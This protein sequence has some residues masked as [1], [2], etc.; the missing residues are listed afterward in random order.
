MKKTPRDYQLKCINESI[1]TLKASHEPSLL[2]ACV[3]SGKSLMLAEIMRHFVGYGMNVLCVVANSELVRSNAETYIEQGGAASIFCASLGSRCSKNNAVFASP[4]TLMSAIKKEEEISNKRFNL[5]VVDEAHNINV[6]SPNSALIKIINHYMQIYRNYLVIDPKLPRKSEMR[7]LGA[8]GTNF[9]FKGDA[10][11]HKN[12]FFKNQIGDIQMDYLIDRGF[13]AD[14]DYRS[15]LNNEIDFS[16]V[17]IDKT[18]RF[19]GVELNKVIEEN[20]SN[21]E[22][23]MHTIRDT[24]VNEN[25]FGAF[26]FASTISHCYECLNHLPAGEAA[27]IIG[28]TTEKNRVRILNDARAGKI[29]YLINVAVL[30]V[31]V[32]V[33]QYDMVCYLRPTE[34][35]VLMVQTVG[36]GVRL[37]PVNSDKKCV[38]LDFA[39]NLDRHRDIDNPMINKALASPSNEAVKDI[40][41]PE[42]SAL[43]SVMA[44]RCCGILK[45]GVRC[46]FFF[47]F[48]PCFKCDAKNDIAARH[49]RLCKAQ[50]ID[51]NEKLTVSVFDGDTVKMKVL[52]MSYQESDTSVK[53]KY[54]SMINGDVRP[55]DIFERVV[56]KKFKYKTPS[57]IYVAMKNFKLTVIQKDF[58]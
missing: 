31:G 55:I 6:K 18:G 29:K 21:T 45:D 16:Q 17:S 4:L 11:V 27:I 37:S 50:L 5:I 38:V 23:I 54:T 53:I 1:T 9:R 10:L 49:C 13:L 12:G 43:N 35:L 58:N 14:I 44:R 56:L 51:P 46:E 26:I 30:T 39:G 28:A 36:R 3:G 8:T 20:Q 47:D 2:M 40:P 34:S 24:L 33:P 48:K 41:C 22:V 15:S 7:V 25:R 19:N 57:F 52:D 42:C 32:D